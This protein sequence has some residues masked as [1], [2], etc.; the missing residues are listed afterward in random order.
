MGYYVTWDV[1]TKTI[2]LE[3]DNTIKITSGSDTAYF[4]DKKITLTTTPTIY[5]G[6][7]IMTLRNFCDCIDANSKIECWY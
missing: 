2:L 4:N 3:K 7:M 5:Q 6:R 1:N